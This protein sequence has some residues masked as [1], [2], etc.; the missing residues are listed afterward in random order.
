MLTHAPTYTSHTH[1]HIP[2]H[3]PIQTYTLSLSHPYTN[4]HT[5][6]HT[7]THTLKKWARSL[8]SSV[9]VG[10]A[11][12][13]LL[14]QLHKSDW[15]FLSVLLL[16]CPLRKSYIALSNVDARGWRQSC[17]RRVRFRGRSWNGNGEWSVTGTGLVVIELAAAVITKQVTK[18]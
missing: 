6:T 7:H 10:L 11:S 4:P 16:R 14:H 3:T 5:H 18:G 9:G 2:K 8:L 12:P 17:A 15:V 13:T 1:P